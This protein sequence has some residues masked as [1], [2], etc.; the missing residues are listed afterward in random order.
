[1]RLPRATFL[2]LALALVPACGGD[3]DSGDGD[4][5]DA[6][7]SD[8]DAAGGDVADA[9][10]YDAAPCACNFLDDICEADQDQ[11]DGECACD[12]DCDGPAEACGADALCDTWCDPEGTCVDPDCNALP[13]CAS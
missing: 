7:S 4:E 12:R 5:V 2:L 3:D 11:S 9:S 1:M 8:I 10:P 6:S 13:Q